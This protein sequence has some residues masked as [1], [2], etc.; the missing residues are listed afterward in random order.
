MQRGPAQ[1]TA[2]HVVVALLVELICFRY[3]LQLLSELKEFSVCI[4]IQH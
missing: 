3:V 1:V 2:A 4:H